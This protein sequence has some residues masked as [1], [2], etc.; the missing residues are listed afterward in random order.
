MKRAAFINFLLILV[1]STSAQIWRPFQ[2]GIQNSPIAITESNGLI[3]TAHLITN[4]NGRRVFNISIWNGYYW[5]N[6]PNIQTDSN[7]FIRSLK[8]YKKALYIGGKFEHAN[9]IDS[10]KNLIRWKDRAYEAIPEVW[11]ELND[12]TRIDGMSIYKNAMILHGPF[13]NTSSIQNGDNIVV[14]NGV[15]VVPMPASF[16]KG[17]DGT[18][19]AIN[20]DKED[21]LVFGGRFNKS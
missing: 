4:D 8:F 17:I 10:S 11:R 15:S 9:K 18:I 12:F 16:G 7:G 6:L 19:N 3:A 5:Q 13:V 14:Y 20:S 21:L 2:D 1:L